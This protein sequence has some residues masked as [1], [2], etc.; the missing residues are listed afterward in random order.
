[1][2]LW[3]S[4]APCSDSPGQALCHSALDCLACKAESTAG[5]SSP[6]NCFRELPVL[7]YVVSRRQLTRKPWLQWAVQVSSTQQ[8]R[9]SWAHLCGLGQ[10]QPAG[11]MQSHGFAIVF[12]VCPT[13]ASSDYIIR[14]LYPLH[15][16][17]EITARCCAHLPIVN[18][19]VTSNHT[20][21]WKMT[22]TRC[23]S[24][25]SNSCLSTCGVASS[26]S[27]RISL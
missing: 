2:A 21:L 23:K 19:T 12:I 15:V 10:P 16:T 6:A 18:G 13:L 1:M 20:T 5:S 14:T 25:S 8:R 24:S 4:A 17:S 11:D 27:A 26:M 3:Q 9:L 22:S 7:G